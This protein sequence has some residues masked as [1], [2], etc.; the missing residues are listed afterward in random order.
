MPH[1][2][3]SDLDALIAGCRLAAIRVIEL[4]DRFGDD[5]YFS[6]LEELLER[7]RRAMRHII[8]TGISEEKQYF[9]DYSRRRRRGHGPLQ[10]RLHHV[11]RRRQDD[12]RFRGNRSAV[13]K[14]DQLLL[15]RRND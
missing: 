12:H 15:Q 10:D 9:E 13:A 8:L 3:R 11:A 5:T 7:T 4:S 14:F 6:A 2:N 1:W